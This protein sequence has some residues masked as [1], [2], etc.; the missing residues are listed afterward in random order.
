MVMYA[1]FSFEQAVIDDE[2]AGMVSRIL[3]GFDIKE[4]ILALDVIEEVGVGGEYLTHPHTLA[5]AWKVYW[6]PKLFDREIYGVWEQ[7][8]AKEA[9]DVTR[10]GVR[11]IL[12]THYP[13]PL[14]D[15]T[16]KAMDEVIEEAKAKLIKSRCLMRGRDT[17]VT[18][19][20]RVVAALEHQK[21]DRVPTGET[22]VDYT[23]TERA[24]GRKTLY[25]AKW[26]EYTALWEG[27]RDE[28]V[29]SYKRDIVDLARRFEWDIVTVPLVPLSQQKYKR[30]EFLAP[31]TWRDEAGR[32]CQFTP[33]SE[34]DAIIVKY[35]DL[36][37]AD[38]S[39]PEEVPQ[40]DES[41]LEVVQHVVKVLGETHFIV[42]LCGDGSF[43][44]Y[45][46]VG[47]EEFLVRMILGPD[48]VK[49]AIAAATAET[50]V[51]M[52]AMLE[53]GC[54]AVMID[55]DYCG[56]FGPMMSPRHF[57][58]FIFPA[59]K[60]HCDVAHKKGKYLIKHTDGNTWAI[61]DMMI[62]AGIDCWQGIQP[63]IGMD[64]KLLKERFGDR[65]CFWGGVDCATLVAGSP[66][67]VR[68]EVEYAI[69]FGG[70]QGGL[71]LGAGNIL[72]ARTKY[73]NYIA[74]LDALQSV[75][76]YPLCT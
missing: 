23:I 18:P 9:L 1:L 26:R 8:G 42:G 54:D 36:S 60:E 34:G 46:T 33:E 74:M 56:N 12:T 67:D 32:I 41:Q 47:L 2:I 52:D 16:E 29:D 66:Q 6:P 4:A 17:E 59:L 68:V 49:K 38:I 58:E 43:P 7:R 5:N 13:K 70:S 65:L 27:R 48:F 3:Q 24:L 30:P 35:P 51:I 21:P 64:M 55:S 45:Q 10:G 69:K 57:R 22:A 61:L 14:D 53:T 76:R 15:D 73:E 50:M 71:I 28:I 31:Y 72:T 44:Y 19:K 62:E 11:E 20:S 75:G 40:F 63:S 37:S 25:R 39:L